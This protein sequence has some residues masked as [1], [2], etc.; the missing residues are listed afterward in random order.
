M[1]RHRSNQEWAALFQLYGHSSRSRENQILRA[2]SYRYALPLERLGK[3]L[4]VL[5]DVIGDTILPAVTPETSP[6]TVLAP[7]GRTVLEIVPAVAFRSR[8]MRGRRSCASIEE[9]GE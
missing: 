3:G 1:S 4:P 8:T 2:R 5:D 7:D 6:V 9:H